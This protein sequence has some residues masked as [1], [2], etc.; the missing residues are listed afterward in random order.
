MQFGR[1][2]KD[3]G[4]AVLS[5]FYVQVYEWLDQLLHMHPTATWLHPLLSEMLAFD[6]HV[7]PRAQDVAARLYL[8]DGR[9][10]RSDLTQWNRKWR[11]RPRKQPPLP[12][13]K[14]FTRFRP[15]NC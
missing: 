15:R 14:D 6:P 8:L 11:T 12:L 9:A 7:R 3:E 10:H 5:A 13:R 1:E 2:W 4:L